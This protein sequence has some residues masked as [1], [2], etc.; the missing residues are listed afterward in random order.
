[1]RTFGSL[2][3]A[4]GILM[5]GTT[6]AKA[7]GFGR[8]M[9]MGGGLMLLTNPD[10]KK[11]LKLSD[12]Q[13]KKLDEM[14]TEAREKMQERFRD[15]QNLSDD[16]RRERGEAMRKEAAELMAKVNKDILKEDQVKRFKQIELQQRGVNAFTDAEVVKSLKL[17]DE[18]KEKIK[19][20]TEGMMSEMQELRQ[21]AQGD[22]RAAMEKMTELRKQTFGKVTALLTEDQKKSWK[23]LTGEPIEIRM[24]FPRRPGA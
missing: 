7:Q 4:L 18:Q 24:Q 2:A 3:V 22:F 15:F 10:V 6:G 20:I 17:T 23:E 9:G 14:A 19:G 11:E 1:M 16:E 21:S 8:G 5:L 12:E 13:A